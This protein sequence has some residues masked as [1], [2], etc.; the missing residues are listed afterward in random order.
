MNK[1]AD[2]W[3]SAVI[4]VALAITIL[5]IVLA[6]GIPVINKMRDK[7]VVAQTLEVIHELDGTIRDVVREG[8]GARRTPVIKINKGEFSIGASTITWVL[9]NSKFMYSQPGTP[10]KEGNLVITTTNS[11]VEDEFN[12]KIVSSYGNL[13]LVTNLK[14]LSGQYNLAITNEGVVGGRIKVSINE[15]TI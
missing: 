8:P 5:T 14:T 6:A 10:V 12:I 15:L 9:P 2:I 11:P 1:K 4:Y 7:N 13:D 3:I